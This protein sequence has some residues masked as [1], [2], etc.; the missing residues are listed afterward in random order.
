MGAFQFVMMHWVEVRRWMDIRT[1][2]SANQD[3]IVKEQKLST[4]DPGYPGGPFDPFGFGKGDGLEAAKGR[5]LYF[6]RLAMWV[7]MAEVI[8]YQATGLGPVEALNNTWPTPSA[9]P[10]SATW[11]SACLT[12]PSTSTASPSPRPASGRS[13][14]CF[15][16]VTQK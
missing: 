14:K 2:G 5:E 7:F 10:S 9:R 8:T 3:P 1:P 12:T 16:S 13:C 11:A 6:G 15:C 4:V